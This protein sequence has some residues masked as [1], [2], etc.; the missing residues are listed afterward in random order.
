M[1]NPNLHP[2]R[3]VLQ[4]VGDIFTLQDESTAGLALPSFRND[5]ASMYMPMDEYLEKCPE[6]AE[7]AAL[8]VKFNNL[9]L[10]INGTSPPKVVVNDVNGELKAGRVCAMMGPSGAGKTSLLSALS[11]KATYGTVTGEIWINGRQEE[12]TKY[13]KLMGFVPQEAI[14]YRTLTTLILVVLR[15]SR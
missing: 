7:L 4:K 13:K 11:G 3:K 5:D 9:T 10:T 12:L 15:H 2:N 14:T 6:Q 8:N 1:L